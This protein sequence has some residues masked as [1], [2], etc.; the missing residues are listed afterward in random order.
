MGRGSAI[1]ALSAA[2][3]ANAPGMF[4]PGVTLAQVQNV[5][6]DYANYKN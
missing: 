6:R 1:E 5:L 2:R 3:N 4:L